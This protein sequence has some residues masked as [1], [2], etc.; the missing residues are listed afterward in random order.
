MEATLD[1][2]WS[3]SSRRLQSRSSFLLLPPPALPFVSCL[4]QVWCFFSYSIIISAPLSY[5]QP[6]LLAMRFSS[7]MLAVS[8]A[9]LVLAAPGLDRSKTK[10]ASGFQCMPPPLSPKDAVE[11]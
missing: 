4:D 9:S 11:Y 10:R 1:K 5:T 2:E 3:T 7:M 8:V 6:A